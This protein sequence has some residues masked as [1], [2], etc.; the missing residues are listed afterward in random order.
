MLVAAEADFQLAVKGM[1][2][3]FG[4]HSVRLF[5]IDTIRPAKLLENA[6][7]Q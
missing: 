6:S 3:M 1:C 2:G 7:V 4:R 5:Q